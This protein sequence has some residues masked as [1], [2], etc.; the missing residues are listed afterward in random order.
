MLQ[1]LR[2]QRASAFAPQTFLARMRRFG[3]RTH[4]L[5]RNLE[6]DGLRMNRVVI[7]LPVHQLETESAVRTRVADLIA[8]L[9]ADKS[10]GTGTFQASRAVR[11]T[12]PTSAVTRLRFSA[13]T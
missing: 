11:S 6:L 3:E 13:T 12:L 8:H 9:R 1:Y 4:D 7:G 10:R 2:E 5:A